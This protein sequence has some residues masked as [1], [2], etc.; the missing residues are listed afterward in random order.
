MAKLPLV[1]L[2]VV[3]VTFYIPRE[4]HCLFPRESPTREV[5]IIDGLW[6]FRADYSENR[7][8]GFDLKWYEAPLSKV[9]TNARYSHS[10]KNKSMENSSSYEN[11]KHS[12]RPATFF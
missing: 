2:I 11:R 3:G 5:K 6:H 4:V 10:F 12:V 8:A 1:V 7:N 9:N